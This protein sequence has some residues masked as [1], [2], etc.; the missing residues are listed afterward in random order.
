MTQTSKHT[1]GPLTRVDVIEQYASSL[2]DVVGHV[3]V[4]D[5][6]WIETDIRQLEQLISDHS[7]A[8]QA[9]EQVTSIAS[10]AAIAKAEGRS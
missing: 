6:H 8:L 1:P 4:A 5:R 7:Q 2:R 3:P 10:R 9:L